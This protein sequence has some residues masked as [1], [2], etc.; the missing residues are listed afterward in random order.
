M[1]AKL[2]LKL[3]LA[4]CSESGQWQSESRKR[5]AESSYLIA[6]EGPKEG[7]HHIKY[8]FQDHIR[9][10]H[11]LWIGGS[12]AYQSSQLICTETLCCSV[13]VLVGQVADYGT[14]LTQEK[15]ILLSGYYKT[16]FLLNRTVMQ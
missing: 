12:E 10:G 14:S 4:A 15:I 9:L 13:T 3:S 11:A 1:G 16:R 5:V 8:T 6:E 7:V 2:F